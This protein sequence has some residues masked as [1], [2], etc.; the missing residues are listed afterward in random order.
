MNKFYLVFEGD[1][2]LS[3]NSLV[4]MGVYNDR[5]KAIDDIMESMSDALMFNEDNTAEYCIKYLK[6]FS[7]THTGFSTRYIIKEAEL[8]KWEE[9]I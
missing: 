7:Q 8:N 4:L 1:N 3:Q 5:N 6:S 2:H 9:I